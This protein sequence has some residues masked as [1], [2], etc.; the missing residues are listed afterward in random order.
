MAFLQDSALAAQRGRE[1]QA[2]AREKFSFPTMV[3][4]YERLYRGLL[5]ARA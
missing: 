3:A 5:S 2:R 1:N 4:A